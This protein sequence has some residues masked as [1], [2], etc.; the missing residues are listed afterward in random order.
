M[1]VF[2]LKKK[3]L[4]LIPSLNVDPNLPTVVIEIKLDSIAIY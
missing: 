2:L 4:C 1:G 3:S